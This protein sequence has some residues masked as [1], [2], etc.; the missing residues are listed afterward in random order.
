MPFYYYKDSFYLTDTLQRSQGPPGVTRP[1]MQTQRGDI[2]ADAALVADGRRASKRLTP[3]WCPP[4]ELGD[5]F[6]VSCAE[7]EVSGHLHRI[8]RLSEA[9]WEAP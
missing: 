8:P 5:S 2:S 7:I 9:P 4:A 3:S 1:Q 6:R